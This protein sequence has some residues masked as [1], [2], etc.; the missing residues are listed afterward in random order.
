MSHQQSLEHPLVRMRGE[1]TRVQKPLL[2]NQTLSVSEVQEFQHGIQ[3]RSR[4]GGR[5]SIHHLR[6]ASTT[7]RAN[8]VSS[9][10]INQ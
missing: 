10:P 1:A 5:H 9:T 7:Q 4:L 6:A 2:Q 3:R 8:L